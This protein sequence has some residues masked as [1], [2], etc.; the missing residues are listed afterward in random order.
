MNIDFIIFAV[1]SLYFYYGLLM[2]LLSKYLVQKKE[3]KNVSCPV[4]DFY[5]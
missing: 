1:R 3:K 2:D 4:L 5:C